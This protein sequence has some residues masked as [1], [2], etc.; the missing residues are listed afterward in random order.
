[1]A[2]SG[3]SLEDCVVIE[4]Y[5]GTARVTA[6]LHQLGMKS[7]FGVDT[8]FEERHVDRNH[9][10]PLR[11]RRGGTSNELVEDAQCR[12]YLLS[13]SMRISVTGTSNPVKKEVRQQKCWATST[14]Q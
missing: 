7:S 9:C 6:A 14:S 5:A 13:P 1:M 8:S 10:G 12:W 2:D 4:I 11:P 3:A